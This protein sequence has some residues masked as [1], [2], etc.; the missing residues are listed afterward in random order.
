MSSQDILDQSLGS[1][2]NSFRKLL[3]IWIKVFIWLF[4]I[5]GV[6][7]IVVLLLGLLGFTFSIALYGLSTIYPLSLM[8]ICLIGLYL[9]KG[10]VS[11]GLWLGKSG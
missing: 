6:L 10:V 5:T 1:K 3:P 11:Y 7:S 9:L 2:P 4:L 8:G